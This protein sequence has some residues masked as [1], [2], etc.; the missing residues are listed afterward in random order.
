MENNNATYE[1]SIPSLAP[2]VSWHQE[3]EAPTAINQGDPIATNDIVSAT[4][5]YKMRKW[6]QS[7]HPT[8]S[9]FKRSHRSKASKACRG[10]NQHNLTARELDGTMPQDE[11]AWFPATRKSNSSTLVMLT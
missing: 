1:V 5:Q 6:L 10:M 9:H 8:L 3:I 7:M 2:L 11:N 4:A